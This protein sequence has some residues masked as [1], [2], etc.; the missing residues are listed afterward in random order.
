M[1]KKSEV[2]VNGAILTRTM[3]MYDSSNPRKPQKAFFSDSFLIKDECLQR[4]LGPK[5]KN[6]PS[7]IFFIPDTLGCV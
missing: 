7:K 4:L 6:A 3:V 5:F 2:T 1:K